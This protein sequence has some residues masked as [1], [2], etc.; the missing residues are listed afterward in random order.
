MNEIL[1]K[2][3]LRLAISAVT[4]ILVG[5]AGIFSFASA[6]EVSL[7]NYG[8]RVAQEA[9]QE[10]PTVSEPVPM[11]DGSSETQNTAPS[12]PG[13][14][15]EP[16]VDST[17]PQNMMPQG[18]AQGFSGE[19]ME[20]KGEEM[21]KQQEAKALERMKKGMK[22][23]V[24]EIAKLKAYYEKVQAKGVTVPSECSEAVTKLQATVDTVMNAETLEAAEAADMSEMSDIMETVNSCR[25]R[26][27]MLSRLPQILKKVDR[28]VKQ[29][30]TR[31]NSAKKGAPADASDAI[32]DG[33]AI[34]AKIKEG[35]AK[36]EEVAKDGDLEAISDALEEGVFARFDDVGAVMN[37]LMAAKNAKKFL[38]QVSRDFKAAEKT[39]AALKKGGQDTAQLEGILARAK[40]LFAQL[41]GMK[42]GS[43]EWMDGVEKLAETEQEFAEAAGST[44]DANALFKAPGK[45][46]FGVMPSLQMPGGMVQ[47]TTQVPAPVQ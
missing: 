7:V 3:Y 4:T 28:Q 21:R 41:K 18:P 36:V 27:E 35:R 14:N 26:I 12:M 46:P 11:P 47:P 8:A 15:G 34:F 29:L 2:R 20:Q 1:D 9:P 37:R 38:A 6:K 43:E 13:A 45:S 23:T 17:G 32:A 33:D 5:A 42:S 22:R 16:R 31:W 39:I 10:T 44:E 40:D 30:E 25:Q 24:K 19:D